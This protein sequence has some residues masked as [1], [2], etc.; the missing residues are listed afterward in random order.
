[1]ALSGHILMGAKVNH[2]IGCRFTRKISQGDRILDLNDEHYFLVA[3]GHVD[4]RGMFFLRTSKI[5]D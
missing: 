2:R 4:N 3:K 5:C 1:M